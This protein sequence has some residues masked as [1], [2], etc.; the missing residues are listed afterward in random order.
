MHSDISSAR[1]FIAAGAFVATL[2][3]LAGC[4]STR[5]QLLQ[6]DTPD[7]INPS[8]VTSPEAADALRIGAIAR[9]R[10][11]TAGGEGAWL[12]GALITDEWRSA[13]TFSQRN[14]TDQRTVQESNG[15]VQGMYTALGQ[16]RNSA[17]EA[18]NALNT[19]KPTPAWGLGQMW[20]AMGYTELLLAETFCNGIPLGDAS[21][22]VPIYSKPYTN[23]EVYA[24][25]IAHMDSALTFLGATDA[26]TT[27]WKNT[28]LITKA[29]LLVDLGQFTAAAALVPSSVIPTSFA[30]TVVTFSL[31][32]GDN[33]IWS[34]NNSAKRWTV[35]DSLDALGRISNAIPYASLNDPRVKTQGSTLGT[36]SLG[37]GFDNSTNLVA[38]FLWGRDDPTNVVSGIDARLIEAETAL[39]ASDFAGMTTILNALRG[40]SQTLGAIAGAAV[41]SGVMPPLTAP[42]TQTAAV[43]LFFREKALWQFS[44]GFRLGDQRRLVRQYNR[45]Q[46][47]VFPSGFANKSGAFGSDVNF[48][49]TTNEYQNPNFKGCIDRK[50]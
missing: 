39:Q 1:R 7:I 44:R 20:W 25:A 37:R 17:R 35:G 23:A 38:Q 31:T 32:S 27:L 50:A 18:I 26:T 41:T 47:T 30:N 22:G 16:T 28:V 12:L 21:S 40:T 19:Y 10:Q 33:Q 6:A 48:P 15:N 46:D 2:A 14:E 43:D 36:S 24:I 34:L 29:R 42:T 4:E 45:T 49:V 5:N 8:S 11:E 9:V 3:A 13:D